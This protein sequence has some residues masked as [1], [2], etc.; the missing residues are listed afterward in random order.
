M[1]VNQ[2]VLTQEDRKPHPG[3]YKSDLVFMQSALVI[4]K[5]ANKLEILT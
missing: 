4:P 3:F 5:S 2:Q 1:Q